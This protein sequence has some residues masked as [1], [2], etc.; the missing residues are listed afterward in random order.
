M[1]K[2]IS[3][4]I[5]GVTDLTPTARIV[6]L[7]LAEPLPFVAGAFVNLFINHEGVIHRRAFSISS[8]DRNTSTIDLTIRLSQT[9]LVSPLFWAPSIVGTE[10][11]IMGPLG[12][13][14]ADKMLQ[15]HKFLC[16][17]GVGAGV[18]KSLAEHFVH[19][20]ACTDLTILLGFRH[21]ND[22]IHADYFDHLAQSNQ[23]TVRYVLSQPHTD[24][25]H[26]S[27]Y[28]QNHISDLDFTDADVYVC[29]QEIACEA[30]IA[31]VELSKPLSCHH[32]IEGFH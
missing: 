4:V 18:V 11:E 32:F 5:T 3:A 20:P 27:G 2:K 19:D 30:L 16:G 10:V 15:S 31:A 12:L 21:E 8:S 29:G 23:A 17:F 7:T 13:N 24:T 25:T 26:R 14:T 9:G 1:I 28:L 6:T 22:L